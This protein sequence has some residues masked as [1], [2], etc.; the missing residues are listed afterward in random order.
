MSPV[1]PGGQDGSSYAIQTN[2][3]DE[4]SLLEA[5]QPT[6]H[7]PAQPCSQVLHVFNSI[8]KI[9]SSQSQMQQQQQQR[10]K[11]QYCSPHTS[12]RPHEGERGEGKDKFVTKRK[13]M[14]DS[15]TICK[16][17]LDSER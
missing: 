15:A 4:L 8:G 3:E 5:Q 11:Q 9:E 7:S 1:L 16:S 14:S 6:L 17:F 2:I 10:H 13:K 12:G